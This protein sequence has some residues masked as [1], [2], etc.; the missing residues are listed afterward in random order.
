MQSTKKKAQVAV[1]LS[2]LNAVL[3]IQP[4]VD[5][6]KQPNMTGFSTEDINDQ[7]LKFTL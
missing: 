7:T 4:L 2:P 5:E 6:W 1:L 3:R